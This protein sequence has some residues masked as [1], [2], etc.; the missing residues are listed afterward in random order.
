MIIILD[1]AIIYSSFG[2]SFRSIMKPFKHKLSLGSLLTI[3]VS[4]IVIFASTIIMPQF[5]NGI[6]ETNKQHNISTQT[7]VPLVPLIP[8]EETAQNTEN[9]E[10]I[11]NVELKFA[12]IVNFNKAIQQSSFTNDVYQSTYIFDYL[13][14]EL[15][16]SYVYASI[17]NTMLRTEA[18]TDIN[19]PHEIVSS[20]KENG[21][22]ALGVGGRNILN[23][24]INGLSSILD[25]GEKYG[26]P[27]IGINTQ[28]SEMP[29]Y[30]QEINGVS[31][32][33]LQ[34]SQSVSRAGNYAIQEEDTGRYIRVLT[35]ERIRE[36]IQKAKNLGAK[37]I[38]VH[39]LWNSED[40]MRVSDYQK[41][42]VHMIAD[43][44]ADLIVGASTS[45]P[46]KMEILTSF[47]E[48]GNKRNVPVVY[49]LGAL[50]NN[51]R[52]SIEKVTSILLFCNLR[53]DTKNNVLKS[54]DL[55]YT[56][57][58]IWNKKEDAKEHFI[59]I[60]AY[61]EGITQME[62][63]QYQNMK[64]SLDYCNQTFGEMPITRIEI[65]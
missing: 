22:N 41:R 40:D 45:A 21:V 8:L 10:N 29:I 46:Q 42:A 4:F 35:Q 44:G 19:A 20:L 11:K 32:A 54:I 39:M 26:L 64:K 7:S 24:G 61:S 56:P 18:Y 15:D 17:I 23:H 57:L 50:L 30:I 25:A 36:D 60:H 47:D 51:D 65:N 3:I 27:I 48:K 58:Y 14:N 12:G 13:K 33:I 16:S 49:S 63:A 31:V 38:L 52:S 55:D 34:F 28:Q 59:P 2:Q 1:Y 5:L 53:F 43:A 62:E 6:F 37:I 9:E